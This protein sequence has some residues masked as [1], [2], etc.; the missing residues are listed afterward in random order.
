MFWVTTRNSRFVL[1]RPLRRIEQSFTFA[2]RRLPIIY[3]HSAFQCGHR[4][5]GA[6]QSGKTGQPI[7]IDEHAVIVDETIM[8]YMDAFS[9]VAEVGSFNPDACS[10][11]A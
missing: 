3:A 11:R 7:V 4:A 5:G 6:A 1:R 2:G 9:V 8:A 10:E